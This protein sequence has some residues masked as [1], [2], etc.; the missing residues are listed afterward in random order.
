VV[1]IITPPLPGQL[2]QQLLLRVSALTGGR[3][4]LDT[5]L[6]LLA[7]STNSMRVVSQ[8]QLLCKQH[9]MHLRLPVGTAT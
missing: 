1:L 3:A 2:S 9:C 4:T 7:C 6:A 5:L 8:S